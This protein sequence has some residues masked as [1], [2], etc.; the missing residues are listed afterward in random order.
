[1][2]AGGCFWGIQALY[3]RIN[4]VE[5]AVS[6]Y[7]GGAANTAEY[8]TS[9]KMLRIFNDESLALAEDRALCPRAGRN[10]S[11]PL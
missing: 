4:G 1:M 8:Y 2:L 3:Q 5:S 9:L 7:S 11:T 10:G 6:G